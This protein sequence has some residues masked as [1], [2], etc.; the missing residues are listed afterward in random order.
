MLG[1]PGQGPVQV[2]RVAGIGT[3]GRERRLDRRAVYLVTAYGFEQAVGGVGHM[4]IVAPPAAGSSL[5]VAVACRAG[6]RGN[7]AFP[8]DIGR[9]GQP[10]AVGWRGLPMTPTELVAAGKIVTYSIKF[11]DSESRAQREFFRR[12][13]KHHR[14]LAGR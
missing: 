6:L 10:F 9:P 1:R 14:R 2:T 8:G 4:A 7:V 13:L 11:D 12:R 5:V 3:P